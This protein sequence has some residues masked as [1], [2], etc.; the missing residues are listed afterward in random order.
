MLYIVLIAF[1][2][3]APWQFE[4]A[5]STSMQPDR[6]LTICSSTLSSVLSPWK[7]SAMVSMAASISFCLGGGVTPSCC[8][9]V[10]S[11]E[12]LESGGF[13][14]TVSSSAWKEKSLD[15]PSSA[16]DWILDDP[17]LHVDLNASNTSIESIGFAAPVSFS[18]SSARSIDFCTLGYFL[19]SLSCRIVSNIV[20]DSG[21]DDC[22][23][24]EPADTDDGFLECILPVPRRDTSPSCSS[25]TSSCICSCSCCCSCSCTSPSPLASAAT[26]SGSA[27]TP[28]ATTGSSISAIALG[29]LVSARVLV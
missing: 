25:C 8:A 29:L 16:F 1:S 19:M 9:V 5:S 2:K 27:E 15:S 24:T 20:F 12:A 7:Q 26:T 4:C 3:E 6:A 14:S 28:G 10:W 22:T 18:L 17:V 13:T 11:L 23:F 21:D